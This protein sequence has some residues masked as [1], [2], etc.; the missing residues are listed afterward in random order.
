MANKNLNIT[1]AGG[2][3]AAGGLSAAG[4]TNYFAGNVGIGVVS[5]ASPLHVG[6]PIRVKRTGVDAH[7]VITMD[8]NF[9]F[10]AHD[11]YSITFHTNQADISNTE[12]VRF[13]TGT[14]NVGIGTA[15]PAEKL[16]VHGNISA[17][18]SLSA[19]GPN[20]NYF[21]GN[22]GIGT[23][24]PGAVL[25]LRGDMRLDGSATDRSIYF[26]NQATVAK[27]RSDAALQFD[28]G[29][30]SSPSIA[31]YIAEDTRFVGIGASSPSGKLTICGCTNNDSSCSLVVYNSAG[32][33]ISQI[34]DDGCAYFSNDT[35]VMGNL[36]VHGDLIYI[37][38]AV[39]VTSAL[40]VINAG[41]G[42]ALFVSQDGLQPIA[43][44]VDRNG[45]DIVFDDNGA[46]GIGTYSPAAKLHVC[47]SSANEVLIERS[48]GGNTAIHYKNTGDDWYAGI[49]SQQDFSI[50][51]NGDIASGTEF[52][53]EDSTG[54]VSLG[55]CTPNEKL[56]VAGNISAS[57]SLSASGANNYFA[58]NVGIGTTSPG[59]KLTVQG[60][61]SAG[62]TVVA[63]DQI[64]VCGATPTMILCDTTDTDDMYIC[65]SSGGTMYGQI[66]YFG[67]ADLDICTNNRDIGL[68]PGT[69]NVGIGTT[70]PVEKLTVAGN[71][72]ASGSL[73][74]SS[75][76]SYLG[77]RVGI[78][79]NI[80]PG[81][82]L[83]MPDS[84]AIGLGNSG[85]LQLIHD[86]THGYIS[87]NT[88]SLFIG[89]GDDNKDI[90]FSSDDGSGGTEIYFFL[91][92][93]A[94]SIDVCNNMHFNDSVQ[95][96]FGGSNTAWELEIY[97]D[98]SNDA[99]IDKT[100]TSVGDLIIQN[101]ADN[102]DIIFKSDDGNGG[103]ATYFYLNG[104]AAEYSGGSI[105]A[106]YT[107]FPD[108]SRLRFGTGNDF[109]M[110]HNTEDT[111]LTNETGDLYIQ[112]KAD[113]KDII[114]KSDNG[115]GGTATY[116]QLDGSEETVLISTGLP[117]S[118]GNVGIGTTAPAEKL[119][120]HGN[121]SASGSLSARSG[122]S[123]LGDRVA[124]GCDL[125]P[126]YGLSMPDSCKIGLGN[127]G[128]FRLY[129]NGTN[130]FIES[131]GGDII[132]YNYDHGNDIKFCA[133]NDSGTAEQYFG[134]YS[135]SGCTIFGKDTRHS[136]DVYAKFGD[137]SDLQIAHVGGTYSTISNYTGDVL[138][139][140]YADNG[141]IRF[142]N[143]D[144]YGN[145]ATYLELNGSD[146]QV[147]IS[148]G[149]PASAGEVGIG[150]T[151]P[152]EKLTVHGNI[153]ASGSLSAG[154]GYSYL[155]DRVAIGCNLNPEYGL[156]MPDSCKIGLGNSG[157]L[158][159]FHDG[160]ASNIAADGTGNLYI[161]QCTA[162]KDISFQ[163]DNG[164]GS[165]TTYFFLD[166][167]AVNTC[168]C[169]NFRFA[170]NVTAGFGTH[171]DFTISHNDT[172]A[173]LI[174]TK[175][176]ITT[177]QQAANADI[178]FKADDGYGT[179]VDYLRMDG[180]EEQVYISTG[181]P[182]SAGEVG[183]GTTGPLAK[184]HVC[185][186]TNNGIAISQN[187]AI[188]GGGSGSTLAQLLFWNGTSAYYGRNSGSSPF[189]D[190]VAAHY[191]RTGGSD[192]MIINSTGVGIGTTAPAETLTVHGNISAS[193]SLSARSGY[194]YLG[195][196][197][198]IGCDL[199]PGYGLSMPDSCSI[200]LGNSGDLRFWHD[201]SNSYIKNTE[202]ALLIRNFADNQDVYIETDDGYGSQ[203]A[204]L[205][206]DGS[207]E[208]LYLTSGLPA[209]AG[210]VGIGTTG[211]KGKLHVLDGSAASY[212]PDGQADTVVIESA[213]A[214]GIS[215]IGTGGGSADKQQIM[216]GT[217]GNVDGAAV[218]YDPNNSCM[219]IG[220]TSTSNFLKLIS[221]NGVEAVRITAGLDVGIGTTAPAEKLTVA[222]NISASGSLSAAGPNSNYFAGKVGIG[223][224]APLYPLVV[225]SAG[226]GI[227]LDITDGV[228]AN[229]R[230][231]V[232]GAVTEVGPSTATFAL[233]AGGSERM[234]IN[235]SGQFAMNATSFP[236]D[237]NLSVKAIASNQG[238]VFGEN[239]FPTALGTNGLSVEGG[240]KIGGILS[241]V[242]NIT[243]EGDVTICGDA[244][245]CGHFSACT[246]AFLIDHP[247]KPGYKLKHGAVEAP[248]W[249]VQYRGNTD[250]SSITL[251]EY[252]E[253][254]VRDD[255]VSTILTPVGEYQ[256]LYVK[257]QDNK[258]VCVGGISGC[259]NYVVYGERKDID[260]M[261]VEINGV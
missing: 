139:R 91:D 17:S 170:D 158:E 232:N 186:P 182:A 155:G 167:S 129:H 234:R 57:G 41:T 140:Q 105:D 60:N 205:H 166:G 87:N 261:E 2:I 19:A 258:H 28:V 135:S 227:K 196:R 62:G 202:G 36:S 193:G 113:N 100:A 116:I 231:T 85:D 89:N 23:S 10:A 147:H 181:L 99:Y 68:L 73:S 169:K 161:T 254:L 251:P 142:Q 79:C 145:T 221:G 97:A 179:V 151:A 111:I 29:V 26:R 7:G 162:D 218:K 238:V 198:A 24:S 204:Y 189:T 172:N 211:P 52:R 210:E 245:V 66:G 120:V 144:G 156:S 133:E 86:G 224:T 244:S 134:I 69:K 225:N 176:N 191:F 110:G 226:D 229:F 241:A 48:T 243:T 246:K 239:A 12:I 138:F 55:T 180:G 217:T 228:D 42:P 165:P 207:E 51:Q 114:L 46:V 194:S 213:T 64:I 39:T 177:C 54:N 18:G 33:L 31:M 126:G 15:A 43:H 58:G 71:I 215:L 174:G 112:N 132:M 175:G 16:T 141:D 90:V 21:A 143:D 5:P 98:A 53:I 201:G 223:T 77:D 95:A 136:D 195:D 216:F 168:V 192:K 199:S 208:Q 125:S 153:S 121:I 115:Y 37:D 27:V 250:Q 206:A 260:K 184:L 83:S 255:S 164:S 40:S 102:S 190:T 257:H 109:W 127:S 236:A 76:Y 38:T 9:K 22:V 248:E 178:L 61:I 237:S 78:G 137:G 185:A 74:A 152:A 32:T 13:R 67:N 200:G 3:S 30:S 157:D 259:F 240:V 88:G 209:S 118:A 214:G 197:V 253:G 122:Y 59:A 11:G 124:I 45:D 119:T 230:V 247:T 183:I 104:G 128:D 35:T 84:C 92:G 65:F 149:L 130:N 154:S 159:I 220:T 82:G 160:S 203:T 219:V 72:S 63:D 123:Y 249:G 4:D 101:N 94:T 131:H 252:W 148:T 14:G 106:L 49:T 1:S 173:L 25:D 117:A 222:G 6:G 146:E 75:G 171:E 80:I 93:S 8:G 235:N 187:N 256:C 163:A 233:M 34:R 81:Y 44:F 47:S 212:T 56:T 242:G 96:N 20:S 108:N 107:Q 50:S 150:T 188:L 70:A 103:L